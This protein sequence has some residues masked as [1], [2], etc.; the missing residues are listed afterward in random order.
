MT[1]Y[2]KKGTVDRQFILGCHKM[3]QWQS[4]K[5]P[6]RNSLI[7]A[8]EL[9]R[10]KLPKNPV[11]IDAGKVRVSSMAFS[12]LGLSHLK[13]LLERHLRGDHGT[14]RDSDNVDLH[15]KVAAYKINGKIELLPINECRI[16]AFNI[17]GERVL[18]TT[19][20]FSD[21]QG[22]T[23]ELANKKYRQHFF[24]DLIEISKS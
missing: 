6:P 13:F 19:K 23:I 14:T 15:C 24:R 10:A 4:F 20:E 12:F 3:S 7:S 22:T 18:I 5:A 1:T 8:T 16:S 2:F 9:D 17:A 21:G 11:D